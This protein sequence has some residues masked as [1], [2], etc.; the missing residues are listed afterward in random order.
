MSK[1]PNILNEFINILKRKFPSSIQSNS[2][3]MERIIE[4]IRTHILDQADDLAGDNPVSEL[5]IQMA[6]DDFGDP[7][8]I[9]SD[10]E[11]IMLEEDR[12]TSIEE[13]EQE[14]DEIVNNNVFTSQS[15]LDMKHELLQ[16]IKEKQKKQIYHALEWILTGNCNI[17]KQERYSLIGELFNARPDYF[18]D[19]IYKKFQKILRTSYQLYPYELE[20]YIIEKFTLLP[21]EIIQTSFQGKFQL[22]IHVLKGRFY[23]TNRRLIFHGKIEPSV[24]AIMFF[25][26]SVQLA[27]PFAKNEIK[28]LQIAMGAKF[29]EKP[30]FGLQYSLEKGYNIKVQNNKVIFNIPYDFQKKY[31]VRRKNVKIKITIQEPDLTKQLQSI[32]ILTQILQN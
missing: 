3:E 10:F 21:E 25:R 20:Q 23:I 30:C 32:Q 18:K 29:S 15:F 9:A 7:D 8:D 4:E 19:K 6:L 13:N 26:G 11:G 24:S 14:T 12:Y 1:K 22:K 27:L 31:T 5:H 28:S 16:L 2:Q 17:T